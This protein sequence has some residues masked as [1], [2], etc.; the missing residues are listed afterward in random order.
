MKDTPAD[1][2]SPP[3]PM[4]EATG[5]RFGYRGAGPLFSD[6]SVGC[7]PG[8]LLAITGASGRGKSTLLWM[9]GLMLRPRAGEVADLVGQQAV[10][11]H[12]DGGALVIA[13]RRPEDGR[14]TFQ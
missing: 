10:A 3:R 9:L 7:E 6:L 8:E 5:I 11:A 4:I 1:P 13:D 12:V 14:H 2:V